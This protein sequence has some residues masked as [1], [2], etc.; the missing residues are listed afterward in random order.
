MDL[1]DL[2]AFCAELNFDA[3]DLTAY[4]FPGYPV[5]P[6]DAYINNIKRKAFLLGLDISGTGIKNDFTEPDR[7]KRQKDILLIRQW[8][9]FAAKLGAP[10]LRVFAGKQSPS[11]YKWEQI[12][13]GMVKDFRE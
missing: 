6:S 7:K 11:G 10:V 2:L 12:A 4:Y 3:V 13:D 8:I 9:D 1:D 5:P